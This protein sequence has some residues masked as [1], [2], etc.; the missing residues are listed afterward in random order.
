MAK[1]FEKDFVGYLPDAFGHSGWMPMLLNKS[2]ITGAI[3]W[4]GV[5]S[6]SQEFLW[7]SPDGSFVKTV[8]LPAG[9]FQDF[10]IKKVIKKI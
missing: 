1:L 6:N 5:K 8:Y 7:H 2:G 4:R 3:V 9:Y 10:C